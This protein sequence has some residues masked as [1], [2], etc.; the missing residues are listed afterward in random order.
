VDVI[1]SGYYW[2]VV[3]VLTVGFGVVDVVA[4]SRR[5]MG[6][7]QGLA[8]A[9]YLTSWVIVAGLS[10]PIAPLGSMW[11]L[12][13][14]AA[15][16]AVFVIFAGGQILAAAARAEQRVVHPEKKQ[17]TGSLPKHKLTEAELREAEAND[18]QWQI[19]D[20]ERNRRLG[21]GPN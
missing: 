2:A 16:I 20:R 17:W 13:P 6:R 15:R 14:A 10:F 5:E 3:A 9:V 1:G 19:E 4:L 8:V 21:T 12:F 11:W 7:A 18:A